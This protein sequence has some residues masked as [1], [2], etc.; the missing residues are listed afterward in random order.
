MIYGNCHVSSWAEVL[1]VLNTSISVLEYALVTHESSS[2]YFPSYEL[3]TNHL[4]QGRYFA[5]NLRDINSSRVK[6]V[7]RNF[8]QN[9]NPGVSHQSSKSELNLNRQLSKVICDEDFIL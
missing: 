2:T 7:M 9:Y 8:E 5:E 3:I 6:L 1:P 4:N